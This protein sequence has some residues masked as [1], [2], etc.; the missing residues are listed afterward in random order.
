MK[1]KIKNN[2][3]ISNCFYLIIL[4]VFIALIARCSYLAL[5]EEVDGVNLQVFASNR[6][7]KKDIL[8]AKR[9]TIYD[10]KGEALAQNVFSYTLIAYLSES[11]GDGYYVKDKEYTAKQL[12]KVINLSE[13]KILELLN[14]KSY[15]TEFSTAGKGLT[16]ITKD[17][18]LALG[19]DGIDFVATQK[20]Y[21]PKGDF[22]SYT[23]GYAK[24]NE[25]GE[26]NGEMGLE[27]L[28]NDKLTGTDGFLLYQKDLKGYKISNTKEVI[29]ESEDGNNI[30]LTIDSSVQFL[31]EQAIDNVISKYS[32]EQMNIV[33][34]EAKTGKILAIS[35]TPSFDPNKRNIKNYLDP[36]ISVAIEPGSTMKIFSYMAVMESGNYNG[37]D[38]FQSGGFKAKDGTII[39]DWNPSGWG[40]ITYDKGFEL[41]SN[42]AIVNLVDKYLSR[43]ELMDYYK[44]LGFGS[45]TGIELANESSGKINFKYQTEVLNAAF[46]QGIL[47]TSL[48]Y[49]K[50]LTAVANDGILLK[51]YLVDKIVD[52]NGNIVL[53]NERKELGRV[54]SKDTTDKIKELMKNVV[55][56]GT[57][58]SY[59][60]EGY[61]LIA[62][63]GTAQIAKEDGTGYLSGTTNVIRGFAGMYPKDDPD[64]IIY[65]NMVKCK[66]D[67]V[68]PLANVVK[69][70]IQNISKIRENP[71]VNEQVD[72]DNFEVTDYR[73][74]SVTNVVKEFDDNDINYV[75]IGDGNKVVN[76]YPNPG[77]KVVLNDKVFLLTDYSDVK[78]PDFTGWSKKDVEI[79]F[80]LINMNIKL[81]G[82]GYVV[83]QN[84]DKNTSIKNINDIKFILEKKYIVSNK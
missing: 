43:E 17:K 45:K 56:S 11:R 46:G 48:Q 52:S 39:N 68:T 34:A 40:R 23:L 24:Q 72:V 71:N 47:T 13:S 70:V 51:P 36:N 3:K 79:Y 19:L 35:T 27:K 1:K 81:E 2:I 76:Q 28:Y 15:Q 26:I 21:Y 63:T 54:A 84:F 69:E 16:E 37:N 82:I 78:L 7:T 55:N 8:S 60:M 18:I 73:N 75:I 38:T 6:T 9:G 77:S 33:V 10:A 29:Q 62:K 4:F 74:K 53:E 57:G 65:A 49:I 61:D 12:S 14:K 22:L 20:R 59:K 5:S 80:N 32:F 30:Y 66:N 83:K 64:I 25:S 67:T 31:V 44:K 50:A 41:S 58:G 42:V